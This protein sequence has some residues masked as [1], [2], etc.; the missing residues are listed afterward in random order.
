MYIDPL[1]AFLQAIDPLFSQ[2]ITTKEATSRNDVTISVNGIVLVLIEIKNER[3]RDEYMQASRAYE[4]ITEAIPEKISRL[5][6]RGAPIFIS[7][8]NSQPLF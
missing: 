6:A 7:C 3:G 5:L 8:L 2:W 1:D 4:V